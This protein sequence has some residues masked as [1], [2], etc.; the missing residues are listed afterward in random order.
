MVLA[1]GDENRAVVGNAMFSHIFGVLLTFLSRV[2]G[3]F[4]ISVR[5]ALFVDK[6][7][8]SFNSLS[9]YA[10]HYTHI[11]TNKSPAATTIY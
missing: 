3:I 7:L 2:L 1:G 9:C 4:R 5:C 6:K 11:S 8:N 10:M